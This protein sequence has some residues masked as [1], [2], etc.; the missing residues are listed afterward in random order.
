MLVFLRNVLSEIRPRLRHTDVDFLNEREKIGVSS[1]STE[2]H[3]RRLDR[4][5]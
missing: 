3:S 1:V 2:H 5:A 4:A